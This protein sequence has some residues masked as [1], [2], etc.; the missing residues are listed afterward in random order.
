MD[1]YLLDNTIY[2]NFNDAKI[3][4][5]LVMDMIRSFYINPLLKLNEM[6]PVIRGMFKEVKLLLTLLEVF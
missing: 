2:Q 3:L 5:L 4:T 6:Y 1:K